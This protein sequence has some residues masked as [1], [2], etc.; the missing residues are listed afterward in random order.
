MGKPTASEYTAIRPRRL[1]PIET[2]VAR[3]V[4]SGF[5]SLRFGA[6]VFEHDRDPLMLLDHFVMTGDTFA[7]HLHEHIATY[8]T[9]PHVSHVRCADAPVS[10]GNGYRV[11]TLLGAQGNAGSGSAA[12]E[13]TLLDGVVERGAQFLQRLARDRKAWLYVISGQLDMLIPDG[14]RLLEAGQMTS[15]GAGEP[16]DVTI[17]AAMTTHFIL[18]AVEPVVASVMPAPMRPAAKPVATSASS[19]RATTLPSAEATI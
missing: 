18:I 7:P 6:P 13:M 10:V 17:H 14:P 1:G 19:H 4:G 2:S 8:R 3:S 11:R 16:I 9:A 15:I 12:N 5:I